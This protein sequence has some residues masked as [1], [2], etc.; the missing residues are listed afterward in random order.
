MH[1]AAIRARSAFRPSRM[2]LNPSPSAPI[3]LSAGISRSSKKISLVSWFTMF[4]IERR[5]IPLPIASRRSTM[6]TDIP[7]ASANRDR[8]ELGGVGARGRLGHRHRL[9]SQLAG[10]DL[11]QIITL[12]HIRP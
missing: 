6:N 1:S 4:G 7:V 8:L 11:G 5:V 12:L 2:Y 10:G 9:Q 3:K